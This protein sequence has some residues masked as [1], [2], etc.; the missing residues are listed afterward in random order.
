MRPPVTTPQAANPGLTEGAP[1]IGDP[2]FPDAGSSGYDVVRYQIFVNWDVR[3]QSMRS[4]TTF[5]ARATQELQSLYFDLA[6]H[7]D[8][9]QRERPAGRASSSRASQDVLVTPASPIRAGTDFQVVRGLF[10]QARRPQAGQ[11]QRLV[12]DERRVDRGGRARE[13]AW[14]FPAND[15]P[16][17]PALM[18][19]SVRVPAGMEAISVGRLESS[20]HRATSRTSTPGTGSPGSRWPPS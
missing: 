20:G 9:G 16:S 12:D 1:G 13:P 2:Y 18:D 5:S 7:T 17:D 8:R 19:V 10:R 4:T 3:T 15:H 14:W 6:L 11:R